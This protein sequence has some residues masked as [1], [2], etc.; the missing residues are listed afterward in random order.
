MLQDD[1]I[2]KGRDRLS[3][4]FGEVGP[5][6]LNSGEFGAEFGLWRAYWRAYGVFGF[7]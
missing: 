7:L 3:D 1:G 5:G 2:N 6:G 4:V